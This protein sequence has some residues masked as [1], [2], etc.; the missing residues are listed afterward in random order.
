MNN[1][2]KVLQFEIDGVSYGLMLSFVR[3][4]VW[5]SEILPLPFAPPAVDGV[6]NYHGKIIP[7]FSARKRFGLRKKAL[8]TSDQFII[9]KIPI[10]G[11][12][13]SSEVRL[14]KPA[15]KPRTVAFL[16]DSTSGVVEYTPDFFT[17]A[18]RIANGLAH[19]AG[20]LKLPN[21][22]VL[23]HDLGQFLSD[24]E[25][26]LLDNAL[27]KIQVPAVKHSA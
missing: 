10:K 6:V 11:T 19:V 8:E 5:A 22:L 1:R 4:C 7:V 20:V 18:E 9:C 13:T 23:I 25:E 2:N 24:E 14:E 21:E 15:P 27:H 12:E 3:H 16:V 26:L 17:S